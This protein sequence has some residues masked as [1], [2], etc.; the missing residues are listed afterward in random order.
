MNFYPAQNVTKVSIRTHSRR[1]LALSALSESTKVQNTHRLACS[2]Q[3][4]TFKTNVGQQRAT[5]VPLVNFRTKRPSLFAKSVTL[6]NTSVLQP[7]VN[8]LPVVPATSKMPQPRRHVSLA[9]RVNSGPV[10]AV[11]LNV[12]SAPRVGIRIVQPDH[13]ANNAVKVSTNRGRE[14][15]HATAAR[16]DKHRPSKE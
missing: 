13:F 8:A 7:K 3:A 15:V 6:V 11:P 10:A 12:E 16:L 2:A 4:V 5:C 1:R 9:H 14:Q